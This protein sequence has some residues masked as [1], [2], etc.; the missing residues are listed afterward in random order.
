MILLWF[1]SR[2]FCLFSSKSFIVCG[3]KFR[4]LI[5]FIMDYIVNSVRKF[6]SFFFFTWSFSVFPALFIEET[7]FAPLYI[8]AFFVKDK[9]PITLGL[10]LAFYLAPL[11]YISVFVPVPYSLNNCGFV[12]Y[13]EVRKTD[14]SSS[15]LLSQDCFSYSGSFVFPYE[16]WNFFC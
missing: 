3:L 15:I 16:L 11:V 10:S 1:M 2:A 8:F 14:S 12:V 6:S 13:S 7:I 4:S 9:L 5:H